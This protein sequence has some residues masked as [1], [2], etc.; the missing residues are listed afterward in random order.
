MNNEQKGW[1]GVTL[2]PAVKDFVRN[3]LENADRQAWSLQ[4]FGMLRCYPGADKRT[5]LHIWDHR[6]AAPNVS[7]LHDHPWHFT[8][9][10]ISGRIENRIY[11]LSSLPGPTHHKLR[12]ACGAGGCALDRQPDVRLIVAGTDVYRPGDDYR[13]HAEQVHESLPSHGAVTLVRREF[14]EDTERAHVFFPVGA[15]WVSAEPRP[16]TPAEVEAIVGHALSVWR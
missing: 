9:H 6:Y 8:S 12:I 5:R 2:F 11:R 16:A 14:L 10:V 7:T 15:Q 1:C 13:Q 3:L 4:G